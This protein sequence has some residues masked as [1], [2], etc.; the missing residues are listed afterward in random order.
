MKYT[1]PSIL[2][3]TCL[4]G[5]CKNTTTE[6]KTISPTKIELSPKQFDINNHTRDSQCTHLS[7]TK[8]KSVAFDVHLPQQA[9]IKVSYD[10]I[11]TPIFKSK[12]STSTGTFLTLAHDNTKNHSTPTKQLTHEGTYQITAL[13]DKD[14]QLCVVPTSW[15]VR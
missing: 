11:I 12:I 8:G 9:N 14:I 5:G 13:E 2:L 6:S 15:S 4:L 10:L 3:I 1:S 7:L